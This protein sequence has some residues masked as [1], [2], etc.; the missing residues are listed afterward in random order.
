[1][2]TPADDT[3][4]PTSHDPEDPMDT[5]HDD[6]DEQPTQPLGTTTDG[7]SVRAADPDRADRPVG[8]VRVGTTVW[9]L[10]LAVI[11]L[12][13]LAFALG[14]RFDV[15]L[16]VIGLVAAAGVALLVGTAVTAARR[17]R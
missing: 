6:H 17:R 10:V 7:P 2:T 8:G 13:M 9:G 4:R 3:R 15:E 14:Y 5:T 12:G 16:A 11:G 1:M